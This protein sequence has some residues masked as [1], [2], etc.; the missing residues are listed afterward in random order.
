MDHPLYHKTY[1]LIQEVQQHFQ[2][3]SSAGDTN[4]VENE[5]L[6]KVA[7]VDA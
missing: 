3:L 4:A 6:T 2:Q 7:A 5:I 1:H